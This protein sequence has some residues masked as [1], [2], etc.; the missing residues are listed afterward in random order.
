MEKLIITD[1]GLLSQENVTY[2]F[3][4]GVINKE[5]GIRGQVIKNSSFKRPV[6]VW[7]MF[8][9]VK[10]DISDTTGISDLNQVID[11]MREG[12]FQTERRYPKI[13]SIIQK[14]SQLVLES[15]ERQGR[16]LSKR[17]YSDFDI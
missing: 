10:K 5:G 6:Y 7:S 12:S 8:C 1:T 9:L 14:G 4:Q 11:I 3:E 2:L 17:S 16:S 13:E 15:Y